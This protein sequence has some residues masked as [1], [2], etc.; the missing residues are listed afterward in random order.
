MKPVILAP[1]DMYALHAAITLSCLKI[2]FLE[3]IEAEEAKV[4]RI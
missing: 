1:A 4:L 3:S 2:L